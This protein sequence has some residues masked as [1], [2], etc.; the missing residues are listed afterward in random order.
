MSKD[1]FIS[2]VPFIDTPLNYFTNLKHPCLHDYPLKYQSKID[3][4]PN[5]MNIGICF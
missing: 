2:I 3:V 4:L 1:Y 5:I